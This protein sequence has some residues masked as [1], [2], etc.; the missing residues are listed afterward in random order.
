MDEVGKYKNCLIDPRKAVLS[1]AQSFG[2]VGSE[3]DPSLPLDARDD[4]A[5]S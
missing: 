1:M 3:F 2:Q 4:V 5:T